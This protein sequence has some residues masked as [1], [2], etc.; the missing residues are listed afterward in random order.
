MGAVFR[1]KD[2]QKG[3]R[4]MVK[5]AIR[6]LSPDTKD[7]VIKI[8]Y[9]W[10]GVR[11]EEKL[12]EILGQDKTES[13]LKKIKSSKTALTYEDQQRVQDMFKDSLTFD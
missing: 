3:R 8:L 10:E 11:S 7:N 5:D 4:K 9:S 12:K 1:S 2:F 13:L 6:D